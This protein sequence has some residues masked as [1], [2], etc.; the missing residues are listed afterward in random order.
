MS[1]PFQCPEC[2]ADVHPNAGGCR[3]CGATKENGIW[4]RS[5]SYDGVDLP[6]DDFDYD[7]FVRREFGDDSPANWSGKRLFWWIVA[8]ITLLAFLLLSLGAF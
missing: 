4:V 1:S 5:D 8:V 7:D 2:G 3:E 6:D